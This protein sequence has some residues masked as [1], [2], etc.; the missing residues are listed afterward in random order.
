M[1]QIATLKTR[2]IIHYYPSQI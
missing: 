1:M 2:S